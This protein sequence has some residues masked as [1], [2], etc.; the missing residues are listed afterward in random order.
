MFPLARRIKNLMCKAGLL[1]QNN[2]I[3]I[4]QAFQSFLGNIHLARVKSSLAYQ[5]PCGPLFGG[6]FALDGEEG[7]FALDGEEGGCALGENMIY[8]SYKG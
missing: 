2:F 6:G 4:A 1:A 8:K 3:F 7:G 5:P